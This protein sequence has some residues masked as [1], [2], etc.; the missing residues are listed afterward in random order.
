LALQSWHKA[1]T[2]PP[3]GEIRTRT[4]QWLGL[5]LCAPFTAL[6]HTAGWQEEHLACKRTCSRNSHKSSSGT[7]AGRGRC[8][9]GRGRW[10]E[11]VDQGSPGKTAIKW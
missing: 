5:L 9:A 11:L 2:S 8:C 6:T 3:T 1:A 4:G 10:G 7:G